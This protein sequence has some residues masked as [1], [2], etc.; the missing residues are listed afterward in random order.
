MPASARSSVDWLQQSHH[1]GADSAAATIP[2]PSYDSLR[3][4]LAAHICA[5][6]GGCSA[7]QD[8]CPLR[9]TFPF[10]QLSLLWGSGALG[11]V[12]GRCYLLG[13][14]NY[15][16]RIVTLHT[17]GLHRCLDLDQ[18]LRCLMITLFLCLTLET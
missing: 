5:T 4:S 11:P 6:S 3:I 18:T 14:P 9:F 17:E 16:A 7:S 8:C 10:P 15:Q 13:T 12:G 2:C 1:R